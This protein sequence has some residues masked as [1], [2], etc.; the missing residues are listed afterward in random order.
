[1]QKDPKEAERRYKGDPDVDEFMREFGKIMSSHFSKLG[2]QQEEEQKKT[3]VCLTRKHHRYKC[4]H[5][6][7]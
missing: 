5:D 2:S 3:Q 4:L 6:T 1:M 7:R